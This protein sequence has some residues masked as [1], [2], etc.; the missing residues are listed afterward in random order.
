M[1]SKTE[2]QKLLERMKQE[3]MSGLRHGFF[4]FSLTGEFKQGKHHVT[5]KAGK[6]HKFTIAPED[7]QE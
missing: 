3:I 7:I 2:V 6:N 1:E 4:D 5:L